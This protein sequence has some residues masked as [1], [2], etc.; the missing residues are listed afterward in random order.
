[1]IPKTIH[2]CW[3]SGE[4]FPK[5]VKECI[6][7]WQQILPEYRIKCWTMENFNINSIPF[8]REA[9]SRRKWAFAADYIRLYALYTEGGLYLDS[10]VWVKKSFDD[11]LKYDFFS[12]VEYNP[13]F[14]KLGSAQ[15]LDV[16]G[17]L[18][19]IS[20]RCVPGMCIQA[21]ILGGIKGHP[22]LR[23]CLS[24]YE[25]NHFILPDGSL[26]NEIIAPDVLA[27]VAVDFGYRYKD[28]IQILDSNMLILSSDFFAGSI[29]LKTPKTI[30]IHCCSGSWRD[31][32]IRQRLLRWLKN[33]YSRL[34]YSKR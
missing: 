17:N 7:T 4:A 23:E 8:V 32:S 33:I 11:F 5:L 21:A 28:E 14:E 15:L 12:A 2:F 18:K 25:K 16:D 27:R 22:F 9:C 24:H 10:D 29:F 31:Y 1:M 30:A 3:L 20:T 26:N 6:Q 34:F 19:D 13:G